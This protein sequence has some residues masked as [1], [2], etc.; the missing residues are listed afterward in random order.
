MWS[1]RPSVAPPVSNWSTCKYHSNS[2]RDRVSTGTSFRKWTSDLWRHGLHARLRSPHHQAWCG[3]RRTPLSCVSSPQS[4]VS[5]VGA[6]GRVRV[7]T[8]GWSRYPFPP[9]TRTGRTTEE[10]L[11]RG[12]VLPLLHDTQ[13]RPGRCLRRVMDG[14]GGLWRVV[15]VTSSHPTRGLC[16]KVSRPAVGPGP[17]LGGVMAPGLRVPTTIRLG[18]A[19]WFSPRDQGR[20]RTSWTPRCRRKG[21]GGGQ[22]RP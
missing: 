5:L 20:V 12:F 17:G 15:L 2:N 1:S 21:P 11:V 22:S 8:V 13:W 10:V 3:R 18:R 14:G 16:P 4:L 19:T 6:E 7:R 9:A